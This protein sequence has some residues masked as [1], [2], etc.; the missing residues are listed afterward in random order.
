MSK[1]YIDFKR[2]KEQVGIRRVLEHYGLIEA[3]KEQGER[4]SG[5]C[6]LC[7][8]EG[9]SLRVS[10]EKSCF[11]C[12]RCD[13]GGNVLDFVAAREQCSVREAAVRIAGWFGIESGKPAGEPRPKPAK[14]PLAA[15]RAPEAVPVARVAPAEDPGRAKE[16]SNE[17]ASPR[18]APLTFELK[19][20]REHPW[21]AE[22]GILP[23]TVRE[24]GLGYCSKG[25]MAGRIAFPI[26]NRD[27]GLL[28]YA[29]LW[30]GGNPPE[31]KPRWKYP[32]N[33]GLTA[34][35]CPVGGHPRKG[36]QAICRASD[37]LESVVGWQENSEPMV[38]FLS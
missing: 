4:L 15:T 16:T 30:A 33:L 38:A 21:F 3:L 31:G 28:G 13:A 35:I 32:P 11:K 17:A 25:M 1:G 29:G 12:F 27:G 22:N 20:D 23:E 7:E 26:L 2:L 9:D 18:K 24:F 5:R 6:P 19:L 14:R 37:P 34:V 8:G 36:L 10:Q